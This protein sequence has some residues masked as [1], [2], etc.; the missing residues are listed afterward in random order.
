MLPLTLAEI[1][2][3][4]DGHI[5]S[6]DAEA[7]ATG[8]VIDSRVARA[9][10]LFVALPGMRADGHAFAGDARARGAVAV[11]ARVGGDVGGVPAIRVNDPAAALNRIA[12]AVRERTHARVVAIAGSSGKTCTKQL[13]AAVAG[14]HFRTAASEASYNNELGVPLTI[15]AL[16]PD[17][18]VLV[19]EV[20]SRGPGDI[21]A[22]M[23]VLRPHIG[24]VTNVGPA[25]FELFGSLDTT[26]RA[27]GELIDALPG[28]GAALLNADDARV[29]GM[30]ARTSARVV[31]FGL[32]EEAG[33]RAE[34]VELDGRACARF[35]VVAPSGR[36]KV[37]LEMPGEHMVPNA[38][39]AIAAGEV[40]GV[41]LDRAASALAE[42]APIA[43]RMEIVLTP[44]GT[45]LV[46]DA[47]NANP[48]SA[49][50][51]LRALATIGAGRRTWAVLGEMAELGPI[52][53]HE[54]DRLGRLAARLGIRRLIT[55]GEAAAAACRAARLECMTAEEA[56][57][58]SGIDEAIAILAVELQPGD[59]VLLKGSRVAGLERIAT[60]ILKGDG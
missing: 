19:A 45:T 20:G 43:W 51:A 56:V 54:H 24:V 1:A 33:V 55:V 31:T 50:A 12:A 2:A 30:A 7:R 6:A 58:V 44:S 18:E 37:A 25:H 60:A 15:C 3:A 59:V 57:P 49:A 23:P 8:V 4:C 35:E 32:A 27:K 9:G 40:L 26:A 41:P 11:L 38:L 47:Y 13:T 39:A 10:D 36:A 16:E 21:A 17:T 28:D 48:A 5:E 14:A 53:A 22:L 46:N 34:N 52:S 29:R 42:A